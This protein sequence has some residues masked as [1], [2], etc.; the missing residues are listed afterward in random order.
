MT[1]RVAPVLGLLA[2]ALVGPS[3]PA[4]SVPTS[5]VCIDES[6]CGAGLCIAGGCAFP[7]DDCFSGLK[8]G[9][10]SSE[11]LAGMC[12]PVDTGV[13]DQDGSDEESTRETGASTSDGTGSGE[14]GDGESG[15]GESGDS[16][17]GE[18][19]SGD[20]E[21][22]STDVTDTETETTGGMIPDT[23][24]AHYSFDDIAVP[25]IFDDTGNDYHAA[26]GNAQSTAPAIVGEGLSF[27]KLDRVI[28]PLAVLAGRTAFTIEFYLF[29]S[30][31]TLPRQFLVYYGDESDTTA[32]PNLTAYI[33]YSV[34]PQESGRV[35]W[36]TANEATGLV[37]GSGLADNQWHHVAM[38]FD[39]QGVRLY[40]DHLLDAVD[41][42]V[43]GFL[44]PNLQFIQIGGVPSGFGGF[45]GIIDELRFSE[46]ALSPAQM[47][48]AP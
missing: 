37:G 42:L 24:I 48:P 11:Q 27:D 22:G 8:Y 14:S 46:G 31:V 30:E 4:C 45:N 28:V 13:A 39:G 29:V 35:V 1:R 34:A 12:V 23:A 7:S 33:E 6:Q 10:L 3:A 20:S 17:S 38:T 41:P 36:T 9:A 26:M 40:V 16:E 2:L 32:K 43:I 18:T 25:T 47:Q 19:E 44:D 5:F 15:D 21:S